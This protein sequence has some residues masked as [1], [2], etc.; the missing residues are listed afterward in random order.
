MDERDGAVVDPGRD[1][2]QP[3]CL[4]D[5][6]HAIRARIGG[7]VEIGDRMTQKGVPHAAADEQRLVPS[8]LERRRDGAGGLA[9]EPRGRDP[10]RTRHADRRSASPRRMRAVAPQM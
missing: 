4:G 5:L 9:L 1:G 2:L 8:G 10:W 6:D 7:Q 3:R